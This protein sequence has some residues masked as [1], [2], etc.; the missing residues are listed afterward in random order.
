M[1]P[2]SSSADLQARENLLALPLDLGRRECRT[3][4]DVGQH[5]EAD[6]E[7]VLHHDHVDEAQIG[8]GAG[9]HRGAHEVDRLVELGG[10]LVFR[11][12]RQQRGREIGEAELV[13]RIERAS[14]ADDHPHADDRLLVVEDHHDLQTVGQ[15]PDLVRREAHV[16]RGQRPRRPLGRPGRVLGG[17][18]PNGCQDGQRQRGNPARHRRPPD[19]MIVITSRF[20]FVK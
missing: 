11:P 13:L 17:S 12:L 20:S 7:A 15:R 1:Y 2:G 4:R 16:P 9:A 6:V 8:A 14:G 10:R 18:R 3:P 5:A 19:G